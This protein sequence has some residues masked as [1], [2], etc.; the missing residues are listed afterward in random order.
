[1]TDLCNRLENLFTFCPQGDLNCAQYDMYNWFDRLGYRL[2]YGQI[3]F[4]PLAQRSIYSACQSSGYQ[5]PLGFDQF[6]N[7]WW[8]NFGEIGGP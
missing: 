7:I 4:D 8:N 2:A 3:Y 1:M 6:R 5:M